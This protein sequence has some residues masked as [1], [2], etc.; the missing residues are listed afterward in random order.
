MLGLSAGTALGAALTFERNE[1]DGGGE[2]EWIASNWTDGNQY[3][4]PDSD[5]DC[6]MDYD[7][8]I[9][10]QS[11]E[12]FT[13]HIG[14]SSGAAL[15]IKSGTLHQYYTGGNG[16]IR[17]GEWGQTG[18]ATLNVEGGTITIDSNDINGGFTIGTY[19]SPGVVNQSGG[20]VDASGGVGLDVGDGFGGYYNLSGGTLLTGYRTTIDP[21]ANGVATLPVSTT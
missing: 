12:C 8:V 7:G 5:D 18:G 16:Y 9:D 14:K 2:Y 1:D 17:L 15:T 6:T 20:T 13:L 4:V 21:D 10:G 19:N 3:V 11:A